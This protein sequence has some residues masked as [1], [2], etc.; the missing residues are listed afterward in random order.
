MHQLLIS[1]LVGLV[2]GCASQPDR[3]L[4]PPIDTTA[5]APVSTAPV[6]TVQKASKAG[7]RIVKDGEETLYCREQL[8]TGSHLLK[9]TICLTAEELELARAASR[10]NLEQ[11]QR[12]TPPPHGT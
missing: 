4:A 8:K 5:A 3:P 6:A 1:A 7:Y 2:V 9:E 10:R 12:R 11:M